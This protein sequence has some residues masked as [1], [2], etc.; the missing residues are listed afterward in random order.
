MILI[1]DDSDPD[2]LYSRLM[3]ER[4][5]IAESVVTFGTA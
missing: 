1:I 5:H 3:V 4:A 2:L